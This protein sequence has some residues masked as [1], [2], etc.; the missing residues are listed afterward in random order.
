MDPHLRVDSNSSCHSFQS[1]GLIRCVF[2]FCCFGNLCYAN[3]KCEGFKAAWKMCFQAKK[4]ITECC[5][6]NGRFWKLEKVMENA[7]QTKKKTHMTT[8]I[9]ILGHEDEIILLHGEVGVE[10]KGQS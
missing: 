1:V 4:Q 3:P 10:A 5:F 8:W 6:Q 7:K 2:L 9:L